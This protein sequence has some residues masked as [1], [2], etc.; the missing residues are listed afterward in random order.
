[1][2]PALVSHPSASAAARVAMTTVTRR[3]ARLAP[4]AALTLAGLA[5][6]ADL[7]APATAPAAAP[8]TLISTTGL[9]TSTAATTGVRTLN[10]TTA[11]A[12]P[13]RASFVVPRAGGRYT[14]PGT[15]LTLTVPANAFTASSMTITVTALAGRPV[16]YEFE[17]H[18]TTF[19]AALTLTQATAGTTYAGLANKGA[20]EAGYFASSSQ[21]DV[22]TSAAQVT[23]LRSVR[24]DATQ[25][26]LT[27]PVTHFSG[28]MM[29]SGRM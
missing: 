11:L 4:L 14:V 9:T 6:C 24:A 10:R 26:S 17:P 21:V 8:N 29:S 19:A 25:G 5:A 1:M 20:V 13:V 3:L 7:T 16:A 27:F 23:E 22:S 28:Y 2:S 15:G 18:G 12:A